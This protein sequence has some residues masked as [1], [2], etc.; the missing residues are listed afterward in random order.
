MSQQNVEVVKAVQPTGVD[1]VALFQAPDMAVSELG[2]DVTAFEDDFETEFIATA[3][4]IRP[5]SRGLQGF[6]EAWTDWLEPWHSYHIEVEDHLDAGEEVVSLVL[7][8][9]QTVRGSVPVEHKPAAIWSVRG[10][11][12]TRV[13]FYLER[14]E[15]LDAAGVS[16]K[17]DRSR[18]RGRSDTAGA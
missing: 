11:K 1:M 12:V 10:G 3:G 4:S 7:V 15:A 2:I 13:R 17:P 5:G 14:E 18:A 9:A 8:R 6:A 16:V